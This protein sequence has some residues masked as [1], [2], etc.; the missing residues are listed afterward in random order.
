MAVKVHFCFSGNYSLKV[1]FYYLIFVTPVWFIKHFTK[2]LMKPVKPILITVKSII[3]NSY[4]A[5]VM[6][7]DSAFIFCL[8]I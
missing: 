4:M 1:I 5:N 3:Y 6:L 8:G 7:R 2:I